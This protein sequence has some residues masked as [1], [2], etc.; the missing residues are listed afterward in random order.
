MLPS[1]EEG[2]S[3]KPTSLLIHP[4]T[5]SANSSGSA[6][7]FLILAPLCLICSSVLIACTLWVLPPSTCIIA[8]WLCIMFYFLL[9]F[10]NQAF[11]LLDSDL[12]GFFI[13]PLLLLK[14]S[15]K[16]SKIL[17]SSYLLLNP[18]LPPKISFQLLLGRL[19]FQI[20]CNMS[21][22][23]ITSQLMSCIFSPNPLAWSSTNLSC[24]SF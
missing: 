5:S 19:P 3:Q 4:S 12:L 17:N 14:R 10:C 23:I 20:M 18:S 13:Y 16:Q 21:E 9:S 15:S 22:T 6:G 7:F 8:H 11:S 24:F 2:T 1:K